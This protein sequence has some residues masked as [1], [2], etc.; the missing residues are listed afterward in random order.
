[1][2]SGVSASLFTFFW[3]K[4]SWHC[5]ASEVGPSLTL[6]AHCRVES[7]RWCAMCVRYCSYYTSGR[8]QRPRFTRA[9]FF[10]Y[11]R[12]K[13]TKNVQLMSYSINSVLRAVLV[14]THATG[15]FRTENCGKINERETE[16]W[17]KILWTKETYSMFGPVTFGDCVE[18][19]WFWASRMDRSRHVLLG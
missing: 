4:K 13:R 14:R 16:M 6:T 19:V 12:Q 9:R 8:S 17:W 11:C 18:F 5:V 3:P 7:N 10:R 15:I 2:R 1:M